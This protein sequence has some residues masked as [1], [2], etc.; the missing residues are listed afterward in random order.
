MA[1]PVF[2][3]GL[4]NQAPLLL[5]IAGTGSAGYA[6]V[7]LSDFSGVTT[8]VAPYTASHPTFSRAT[9]AGAGYSTLTPQKVNALQPSAFEGRYGYG[10][11]PTYGAGVG[12][13][14]ITV[15]DGV[16]IRTR[17]PQA[18]GPVIPYDCPLAISGAATGNFVWNANVHFEEL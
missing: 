12:S 6:R 5:V 16:S 1:H 14:P 7:T 8:G 13:F 2:G 4:N 11:P 10:V 3:V 17:F 9:S 15:R 18:S